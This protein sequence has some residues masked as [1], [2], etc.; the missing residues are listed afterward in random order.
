MDMNTDNLQTPF[1]KAILTGLFCGIIGTLSCF[2]YAIT[3][4]FITGYNPTSFINVSVLIFGCN[5]IMVC[6]GVIYFEFRKFIPQGQIVFI[7]FFIL[8]TLFCLWRAQGIQR[9]PV[10]EISGQFK[11]LISGI[12]I[13]LGSYS[14]VLLPFLYGNR[15]FIDMVI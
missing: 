8:V 10:Q 4:R 3:Y 9:S 1:S 5:I 6:V 2:I 14:A 12:I 13:I 11:G 15:K 7:V